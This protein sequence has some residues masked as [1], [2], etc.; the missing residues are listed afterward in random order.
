MNRRHIKNM[1]IILRSTHPS[2]KYYEQCTKNEK[3]E[4]NETTRKT[5]TTRNMLT[6]T[7]YK[8]HT[9]YSSLITITSH[10]H[11]NGKQQLRLWC[12]WSCNTIQKD[13]CLCVSRRRQWLNAGGR[14]K[15]RRRVG[16]EIHDI[17]SRTQRNTSDWRVDGVMVCVATNSA[18]WL[19]RGAHQT[20][21]LLR[22]NGE[23]FVGEA[24]IKSK[25]CWKVFFFTEWDDGNGQENAYEKWCALIHYAAGTF[26]A[27]DKLP[28]CETYYAFFIMHRH[29]VDVRY[30]MQLLRPK[31]FTLVCDNVNQSLWRKTILLAYRSSSS[32]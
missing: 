6:Y 30:I 13:R 9:E 14:N 5:V 18:W 21:C 28:V 4:M 19:G 3:R 25:T 7:T 1:C 26:V 29:T 23:L 8:I 16:D 10:K 22:Q 31:Y 12:R 15:W 24:R 11:N 20:G 17:W 27:E 32:Q 2:W